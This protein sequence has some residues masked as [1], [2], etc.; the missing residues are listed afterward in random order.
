ME[1]FKKNV[2]I[3]WQAQGHSHIS[4]CPEHSGASGVWT[5]TRT[6]RNLDCQVKPL[7]RLLGIPELEQNLNT[8]TTA[9]WCPTKSFT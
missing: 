4:L 8:V 5:R 3:R 9:S 7:C 1:L 2:Q 6:G